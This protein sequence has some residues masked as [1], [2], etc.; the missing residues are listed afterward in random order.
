MNS[1]D[2]ITAQHFEGELYIKA[3]DHHRVTRA[4]VLAEREACAKLC[5]ELDRESSEGEILAYAGGWRDGAK[6]CAYAIRSRG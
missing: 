1:N 3:S 4:A 5:Y 6:D 2:I